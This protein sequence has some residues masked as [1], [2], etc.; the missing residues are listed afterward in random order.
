MHDGGGFLKKR[1]TFNV[2]VSNFDYHISTLSARN[3]PV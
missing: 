3:A 2:Y 1:E